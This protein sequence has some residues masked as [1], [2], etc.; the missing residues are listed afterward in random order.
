MLGKRGLG[1]IPVRCSCDD[2]A[3]AMRTKVSRATTAR[4][5]ETE[6]EVGNCDVGSKDNAGSQGGTAMFEL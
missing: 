5:A 1:S 6:A 2:G 4:E 3:G